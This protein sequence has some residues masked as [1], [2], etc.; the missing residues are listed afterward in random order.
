MDDP[1]GAPVRLL[2]QLVQGKLTDEELDLLEAMLHAE[3]LEACPPEVRRRAAQLA[4]PW[5]RGMP[6]PGEAVERS[7]RLAHLVF[8]SWGAPKPAGVRSYS[9]PPRQLLLQGPDAEIS[10]QVQP[11]GIQQLRLIGQVF[12]PARSAGEAVLR[13]AGTPAIAPGADAAIAYGPVSVDDL[14]EF[15]FTQ[16]DAGRYVLQ[17]Q[18]AA[19][20]IDSVD[21]TLSGEPGDGDPELDH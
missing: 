19:H 14:G 5:P 16:I 2:Y 4:Q 20:R 7:V 11:V 13:R 1:P 6:H 15:M 3:G 18:L 21:L 10:L 17:V 8:D 9:G 12:G